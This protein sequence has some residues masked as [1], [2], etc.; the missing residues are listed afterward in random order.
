MMTE[1]KTI[2]VDDEP[3]AIERLTT[4]AGRIDGLNLIGTAQNGVEALTL[5]EKLRPD[6]ILLD[7]A[8]PEMDGMALAKA[9]GV[10]GPAR[11]AIIFITAFDQFA[12]EAFDTAAVD[13]L[14]KPISQERLERAVERARTALARNQSAEAPASAEDFPAEYWVPYRSEL[15]RIAAS[16]IDRVEAE[17]DYMRLHVGARSYLIHQTITG[18]EAKLDPA[19][20]LR[21]HRSSI[22]RKELITSLG[23][24][25]AGTWHVELT[26]GDQVRVGRTYLRQVKALAGK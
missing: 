1:L 5:I 15:I 6:L 2:I 13:Y 16:E 19:Q 4:L 14:L 17:R 21:L 26:N 25:G 24:D 12:V 22:V 9:V 8:M 11:P 20:F 23:H 18:L 7:I 10:G 3:L